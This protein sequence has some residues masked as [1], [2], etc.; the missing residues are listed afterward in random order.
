MSGYMVLGTLRTV[1]WEG[2]G[3]QR[4]QEALGKIFFIPVCW[5]KFTYETIVKATSFRLGHQIDRSPQLKDNN[6]SPGALPGLVT[7]RII[8]IL[9]SVIHAGA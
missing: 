8:S 3:L 9:S 4:S 2:Q 6:G 5:V 1:S 7:R